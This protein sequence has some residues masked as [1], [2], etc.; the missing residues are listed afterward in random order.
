V[1]QPLVHL[2]QREGYL[3]YSVEFVF[4]HRSIGLHQEPSKQSVAVTLDLPGGSFST[5]SGNRWC[6]RVRLDPSIASPRRCSG[7]TM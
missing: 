1:A 7:R 5:D 2:G 6:A 3:A 4:T